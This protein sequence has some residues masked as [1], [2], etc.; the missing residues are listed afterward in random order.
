M[1]TERGWQ[2]AGSR[3]ARGDLPP[4][5]TDADK[6]IFEK[7]RQAAAGER[8]TQ[9]RHKVWKSAV[10]HVRDVWRRHD[11]RREQP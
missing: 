1:A 5:A 2:I 7:L 6:R 3:A 10:I 11:S 9:T 8:D 4:S